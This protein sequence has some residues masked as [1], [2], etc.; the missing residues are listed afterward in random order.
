MTGN[1]V[2][3]SLPQDMDLDGV[4][5]KSIASGSHRITSDF[6]YA[7]YPKPLSLSMLI[8]M[9]SIYYYSLTVVYYYSLNTH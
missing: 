7:S 3:W 6:M 2:E 4:E 8:I 5:F 1:M 9:I